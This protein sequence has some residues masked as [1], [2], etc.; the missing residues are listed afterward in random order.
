MHTN[1]HAKINWNTIIYAYKFSCKDTLE[2]N[3]I[4]IQVFMQRY[5]GI[6]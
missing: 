2:Y 1:F 5:I 6:Q 3:D 4:C